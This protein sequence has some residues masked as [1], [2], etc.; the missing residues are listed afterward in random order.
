MTVSPLKISFVPFSPLT[1]W[2]QASFEKKALRVFIKRDD[3]LRPTEPSGN[4]WRKLQYNLLNMQTLGMKRVVTMG[5]AYSNHLYALAAAGKEFGLQTV[6]VVRGEEAARPSPTLNFARA[7]GMTL[8]FLSRTDYKAARLNPANLLNDLQTHYGAFY[9]LP[10]GGANDLA[11]KGC[12]EILPEIKEQLGGSPDYLCL[13]CGTGATLH[14]ILSSA[15][16][17]VHTL[18]FAVLNGGFLK[19]EALDYLASKGQTFKR[20]TFDII[21]DYRFGGYGK[22]TPELIDFINDFKRARGVA[23]DPVYTGK[24]FYGVADLVERDYFPAGATVVVLHT[25]G[26]Q[27][28]EG[29]N[30]RFGNLII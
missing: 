30:E 26:L 12:A 13:P 15:D 23:L 1:E 14:G 27:G 11:V 6:A 5:G 4:K 18:G 28:I 21:E 16:E 29:F 25:G 17:K 9:F 7:C 2:K 3:L 24:L 19:Q 20:P 22:W 8:R 10:E